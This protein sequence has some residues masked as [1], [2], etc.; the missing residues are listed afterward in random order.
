M[1]KFLRFTVTTFSVLAVVGGSAN[2]QENRPADPGCFNVAQMCYESYDV[3]GYGSPGLCFMDMTSEMYCPVP[4]PRDPTTNIQI[5]LP[6]GPIHNCSPGRLGNCT[7][8]LPG[9]PP[10]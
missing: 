3:L 7:P 6:G 10:L 1:L 5:Y 4:E 2:A 8:P 9:E